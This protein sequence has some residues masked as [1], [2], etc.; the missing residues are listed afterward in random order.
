MPPTKLDPLTMKEEVQ[1]IVVFLPP[2]SE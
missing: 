2:P 1:H